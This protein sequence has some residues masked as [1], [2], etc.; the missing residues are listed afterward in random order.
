MG[1]AGQPG[2]EATDAPAPRGAGIAAAGKEGTIPGWRR[3]DDLVRL[4][5]TL[6]TVGHGLSRWSAA[7]AASSKQ[8]LHESLSSAHLITGA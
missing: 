4:R 8:S 5:N 6:L 1:D 3:G 7:A 2:G